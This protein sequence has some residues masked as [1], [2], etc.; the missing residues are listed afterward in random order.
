M[1]STAFVAPCWICPIFSPITRV[2]PVVRSASLRTSSAT[3]AK[4]RPASPARAASIAAFNASRFVWS[5]ISRITLTIWLIESVSLPRRAT[6]SAALRT[7]P[8]IE[9]IDSTA[10]PITREPRCEISFEC[11]TTPRVSFEWPDICSML[12]ASSSIAAASA[13]DSLLWSCEPTATSSASRAR[14]FDP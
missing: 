1:L 3:T 11:S 10:S 2:A 4:P 9:C 13:I 6:T 12:V 14:S 5:A 8:A 7:V